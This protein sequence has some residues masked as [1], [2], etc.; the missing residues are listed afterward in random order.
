MLHRPPLQTYFRRAAVTPFQLLTELRQVAQFV[1]PRIV[2]TSIRDEKDRP[3]IELAAARPAADFIITGDKDFQE[4]QYQG[5]P[6]VNASLFV[7][8]VL[9]KG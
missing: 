5:V 4:E 9:G 7:T 6:V 3:F 8:A 1:K 2:K